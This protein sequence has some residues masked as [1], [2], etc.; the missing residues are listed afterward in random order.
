MLSANLAGVLCTEREPKR[1]AGQ[2]Y[3]VAEELRAE[4]PKNSDRQELRLVTE[5]GGHTRKASNTGDTRN[6]N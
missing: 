1:A 4:H 3:A 5:T 2:V 6:L